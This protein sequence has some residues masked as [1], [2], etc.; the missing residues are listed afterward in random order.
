MNPIFFCKIVEQKTK[1]V[2]EISCKLYF[3]PIFIDSAC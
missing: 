2:I 3:D 1:E